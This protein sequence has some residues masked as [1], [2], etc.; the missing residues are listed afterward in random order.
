MCAN[1]WR[2]RISPEPP[3]GR[4]EYEGE[5]ETTWHYLIREVSA[6]TFY[7]RSG[8]GQE[9][10]RKSKTDNPEAEAGG[11]SREG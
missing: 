1:S 3:D 11:V 2:E 7:E 10:G 8:G 4:G 6:L 9:L 5:N